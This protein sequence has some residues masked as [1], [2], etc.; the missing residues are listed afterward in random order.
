LTNV[1]ARYYI[2]R[3]ADLPVNRTGA[4]FSVQTE[5]YSRTTATAG[6]LH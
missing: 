1:L 4:T 3:P 2:V 6:F 5:D